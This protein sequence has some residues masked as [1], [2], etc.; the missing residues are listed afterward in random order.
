MFTPKDFMFLLAS[1]LAGR[2]HIVVCMWEDLM[3][4]AC[5]LDATN[6]RMQEYATVRLVSKLRQN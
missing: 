4:S 2:S 1:R 3:A 5:E 6:N